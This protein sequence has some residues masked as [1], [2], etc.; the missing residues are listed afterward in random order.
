MEKTMHNWWIACLEHTGLLTQ[1]EATHISQ[2]IRLGLHRENYDEAYRELEAILADKGK[3][4]IDDAKRHNPTQLPTLQHLEAR[5]KA[6][7]D[8]AAT[9]V[10]KNVAS[11]T[12]A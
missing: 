4:V 3:V 8:A 1:E 11:K 9:E 2:E 5:V 7:E 12:K 10:K 6:L